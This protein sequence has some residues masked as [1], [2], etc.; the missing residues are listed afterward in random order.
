MASEVHVSDLLQELT[1]LDATPWE[2]FVGFVPVGAERERPLVKLEKGDEK[3]TVDLLLSGPDGGEAALEL[4]ISHKFSEKQRRRYE[5]SAGKNCLLLGMTADEHLVEAHPK[6]RFYALATV[7]EAWATSSNSDA[8]I[9]A[10]K[11]TEVLR[12]WDLTVDAVFRRTGAPARLDTL[13]EK[14]LATLVSRRLAREVGHRSWL[15][16][17]GRSSGSSG[18]ALVQ[19]FAALNGDADRCLI[20]EARWMEGLHKI[21]IRLGVDFSTVE[22]PETR[23]EAWNLA[24]S[25]TDAISIEAFRDHLEVVRPDLAALVRSRGRG[26]SEPNDEIWLPVVE[27]GF[28]KRD[29]PEGV[30]NPKGGNGSRTSIKPG[31]VGDGTLRFEASG[32][33]K[34]ETV[35]AVDLCDLIDEALKHL[36]AELPKGYTHA[37]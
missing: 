6:W 10:S 18:L 2:Q 13:T 14:F 27:R 8:R 25:M 31:F 17:A 35:D 26:R 29:N 4:K 34:A 36:C 30:Q 15:Y 24:K 37:P 19:G 22:E 9:L 11:A 5:R 12:S 7:F 32:H 28:K 3:G 33:V 16:I 21:N 23:A 1:D 20:A